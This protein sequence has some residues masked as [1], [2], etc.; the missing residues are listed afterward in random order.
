VFERVRSVRHCAHVGAPNSHENERR[1]TTPLHV[2]CERGLDRLSE[3]L[4][5]HGA[6]PNAVDGSG[7]T[8]LHCAGSLRDGSRW[9]FVRSHALVQILAVFSLSL[10]CV[11]VCL[12]HGACAIRDTIGLG[13]P[14]HYAAQHVRLD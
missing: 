14:I 8:P 4:V 9:T 13:Y 7:Y 1:S 6:D 12:D 5:Q 11:R 10:A 2:T 3:M